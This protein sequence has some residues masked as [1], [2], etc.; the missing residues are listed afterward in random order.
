M[1]IIKYISDIKSGDFI[2]RL[3]KRILLSLSAI[4]VFYTASKL[5]KPISVLLNA[6]IIPGYNLQERYGKGSWVVITG[7]SMGIGFAYCKA[8]AK[9]GF[10]IVLIS[11]D[12]KKLQNAVEEIK[13]INSE[14]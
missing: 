10:N 14:V 8:F 3:D 6:Y 4:G 7:A 11:R 1:I 2:N 12:E 5:W 13:K 9:R